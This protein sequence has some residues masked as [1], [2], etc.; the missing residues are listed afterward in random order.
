MKKTFLLLI[1]TLIG[2][3]LFADMART[4]APAPRS[5]G[6]LLYQTEWADESE[7]PINI[8]LCGAERG[9]RYGNYRVERY[10]TITFFITFHG[11]EKAEVKISG[12]GDTDLDLYVYD[13]SD[14][15]IVKDIHYTDY[16]LV[17]WTPSRTEEFRIVVKNLGRLYNNFQIWTN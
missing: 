10:S 4:A 9:P 17:E 2:F 7:S 5:I 12:D 15:L 11:G 3:T 14:K 1:L 8:I 16:A 13:S 6:L